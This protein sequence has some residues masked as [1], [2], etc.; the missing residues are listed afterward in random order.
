MTILLIGQLIAVA[1]AVW[2]LSVVEMSTST[3][4]SD[5]N[6]LIALAVAITL[7][8]FVSLVDR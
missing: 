1:K 5:R 7:K 3:T 2:S 6:I 4:L 8:T